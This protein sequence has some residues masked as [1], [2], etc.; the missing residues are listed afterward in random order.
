[1]ASQ[2]REGILRTPF[3]IFNIF[4]HTYI[5][6]QKDSNKVIF[7]LENKKYKP[8]NAKIFMWYYLPNSK[9]L[10]V[11]RSVLASRI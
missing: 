10:N 4:W 2:A 11:K 9:L 7:I 8:F 5:Y 6:N 3:M 1:M